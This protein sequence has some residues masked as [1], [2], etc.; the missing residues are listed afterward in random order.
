MERAGTSISGEMLILYSS[1]MIPIQYVPS[2]C[3]HS[4]VTKSAN[5]YSKKSV[6]ELDSTE[7]N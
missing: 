7:P 4:Y 1:S 5:E 3:D 2:T 6:V